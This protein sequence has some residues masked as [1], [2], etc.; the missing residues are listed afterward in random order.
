MKKEKRKRKRKAPTSSIFY[1]YIIMN[2]FP[3][4]KKE[5]KE[6]FLKAQC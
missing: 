5:Q 2:L 6:S 3:L 4:L 1:D